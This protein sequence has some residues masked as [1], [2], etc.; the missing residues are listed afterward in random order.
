MG[1]GF[2]TRGHKHRELNSCARPESKVHDFVSHPGNLG[3]L[4][5]SANP[6]SCYTCSDPTRYPGIISELTL[7]LEACPAYL[8][9][10]PRLEDKLSWEGERSKVP[11]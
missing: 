2:Y 11:G 9:A 8:H 1:L 3:T 10:L 4:T 6:Y 7:P 5:L